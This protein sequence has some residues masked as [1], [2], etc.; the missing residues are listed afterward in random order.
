MKGFCFGTDAE[1]VEFFED[2]IFEVTVPRPNPRPPNPRPNP[3]LPLPNDPFTDGD[4]E[5]ENFFGGG[6]LFCGGL[7]KGFC[8]EGA[9]GGGGRRGCDP[10][11][12]C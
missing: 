11:R 5:A 9:V 7:V 8:F 12:L 10:G 4:G 2:V 1:E 6:Q 3:P